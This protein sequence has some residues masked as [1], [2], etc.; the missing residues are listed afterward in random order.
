MGLLDKLKPQPRWKHADPSIRLEGVRE[1]D[2]TGGLAALAETDPDVRVRRAAMARVEDA[3]VL[4]RMAEA[5]T[6][7]DLRDR[8]ADRL[9]AIACR[10]YGEDPDSA[11]HN[12]DS[13]HRAVK[14]LSDARRLSAV[15][16]SDA[17]D[18]VRAEALSRITEDRSLGSIAR[19]AKQESTAAA[20]LARLNDSA[21]LIEVAL[22]AGHKDLA[23]AAFERV[24]A[25]SPDL[26]AL[27]TI[28]LRAQQKAV[29]RRA[30]TLIQ[31][32]EAAEAAR[33]TAAL[34][35][36]RRESM[37]C[38]AVEGLADI[39][40][41]SAVR[42]ELTRLTESWR[43]LEAT[44][45]TVLE[46]FSQA[47]AAAQEALTRRQREADEAAERERE[48]AEAVATR[49]ALCE[50]VATLDGDD[51]LAQL[52]PIEEEW[53]S[54]LPLVGHGPE[55]DRLADRFAL[56]VTACRKRHEMGAALVDTRASL[57]TLVGEAEGLVSEDD[58][59]AAAQRWQ[60]LSREARGL[61]AVLKDASRPAEDLVARLRGVEQAFL[62]R[63][64]ARHR[65]IEQSRQE[66]VVQVQRLAERAHR[67]AD[68]ETVTL[69]EGER[70]LRDL[71][72]GLEL[73]AHAEHAR[74]LDH[75]VAELRT[76]QEKVAPRVRELREMDEWRKFANAQRQEQLI[77][78][79]EA[80]V[81]SMKADE[82][83][84][85][86]SDLAATAKAL[87]DMHTEWQTVAEAPRQNAQRLWDRFRTSSDFIRSRC[88]PFF[89]KRREERV[90][91]HQKRVDIV[92]E[93][94]ALAVSTEW[95]SAATRLQALQTEWQ[96]MG[97]LGGE[98]ERELGN[99]FRTAC[100][101]F[102]VRRRE[103]LTDRKKVW[104][105]NL[106]RK[107]ALC[108]RAEEL[109]ASTEWDAAAQ[110]MKRLQADWKTIG[111]VRKNKSEVVWSRFRAAADQFFERYHHRHEI[112]LASKLAE[113]ELIVVEL[114][115]LSS[116]SVED[117]PGDAAAEVQR[118]RT[119]WNRSVPVPVPGMKVLVD[120]WQV[121]L[122]N[123]LTSRPQLFAGTEL[124]PQT[125]VVRMEKLVAR[126]ESLATDARKSPEPKLSA[127]ELMAAK[128]RSALAHNAM[129]G[130]SQDEP[131][132]RGPADALREAQAAW[133]R[134]PPVHTSEARALETRFRDA[135]RRLG[136]GESPRPHGSGRT[137]QAPQRQPEQQ[138]QQPLHSAEVE[139][140]REV[141]T[142]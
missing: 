10:G 14:A 135:C 126:V 16:K 66:V 124:D 8:A 49:L 18:D 114:E 81:V 51:A 43:V 33:H 80:I 70:L 38:E 100:N 64:I 3:D 59:A 12:L 19:H 73:A 103:D 40:D 71:S 27:R 109:A 9:V 77:S 37:L 129:G 5:D 121:A 130:R 133:Q 53:R 87:R 61:T 57:E 54:L 106:A 86:T 94:E 62:A 140:E 117:M 60:S 95:T 111:P 113:R 26:A 7:A 13:A 139:R 142:V 34:E 20:A 119:T 78:M 35:R 63:D 50:R 15:A 98:G 128:L 41:A 79:A 76:W 55:A 93:A 141:A 132:G 36:Q 127:T 39:S 2:D 24:A 42:S 107:E 67:T 138:P 23:L 22:N 83:A 84:G 65:E 101:T 46:R 131:K 48:R 72:A 32:I 105:E 45:P 92:T 134:L 56:A 69:R 136:G 52:V 44:E 30:R 47:V 89:A 25:A 21:E 85:K 75:A 11:A 104:T 1:L 123:L 82:E 31:S 28:E 97:R 96:A 88:E 110:E 58:A 122:G 90:A 115:T 29:S 108:A 6:D 99:A 137:S 112:A 116:L 120:R 4:G 74:E 125:I 118:I 102:F 91:N 68:A 17:P